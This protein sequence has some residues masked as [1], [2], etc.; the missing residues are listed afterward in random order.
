MNLTYD[1]ISGK[2]VDDRA[3]PTII[4]EEPDGVNLVAGD[5]GWIAWYAETRT[6]AWQAA[7]YKTETAA[8]RRYIGA[9]QNGS[10]T[11][12]HY[13]PEGSLARA[14]AAL[15]EARIETRWWR[16]HCKQGEYRRV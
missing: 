7:R 1:K 2:F 14:L 12:P 13:E 11:Y 15:V 3:T 9:V 6:P 5:P 10:K 16:H 8:D 4:A